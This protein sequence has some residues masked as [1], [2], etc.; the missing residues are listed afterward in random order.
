MGEF[1]ELM[2][3]GRNWT[4]AEKELLCELYGKYSIPTI[5]KRLGRSVNSI[6]VM[7]ERLGLGGVL[8]NSEYV[9]LN[10]LMK[11]FGYIQCDGYFK[12]QLERA[13]FPFKKQRVNKNRFDIVDI[14]EF[15]IWAENCGNLF[16]FSRL[17]K[18]ALGA[19]PDWVDKRRVYDGERRRNIKPHNLAWSPAE[20]DYLK[21][22]L[23]QH[24]YTYLE[25]KKLLRRSEGAIQRRVLDL[26]I[27]ERPIK[28][29]NHIKWTDD[30]FAI[31]ADMINSGANYYCISEVLGKSEKA[32]RGRVFCIYLTENLRKVREILAGGRWG[33]NKPD[34]PIGKNTVCIDAED[35]KIIR[36]QM[37]LLCGVLVHEIK[38]HY[39]ES[40]F[41]QKDMCMHWDDR[42]GCTAGCIDCDACSA[43][44]RIR[45][46][47]CVRCGGTFYEKNE[48]RICAA[49]RTARKKQYYKKIMRL[50]A[51]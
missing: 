42:K 43:F 40:D 20:D 38:K 21:T 29:D 15:W 39:D 12:G 36:S 7:R 17:P 23:K 18:N 27:K 24:R 48:N 31:L 9:T 30:D 26:G 28:A 47:Y 10:R 32:I 25:L 3:Q 41:W 44:E 4:V 45:P 34:R 14:D 2:G 51:R 49:C 5:A 37:S 8:E 1:G 11:E 50:N 33:D 46:Q 35:R 19:E 22:L 6:L 16:D 13:G